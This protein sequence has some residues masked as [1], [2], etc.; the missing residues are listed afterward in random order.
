MFEYNID[1][2]IFVGFLIANLGI[3]LL[4]SGG[5]ITL[6]QYAVGDKTFSTATLAA[7]IIATCIGGGFFSGAITESYKQGLYFIIPA[8]GEPLALVLTGYLLAPRM[9]EFLK[10]LSIAEAMGELYGKHVRLITACASIFL[11]TGIVALQFKVAATILKFIFGISSFYAVLMSAIIV[12]MYSALGGVK[13]VTFM[14][15]IQF[16]TFGTIIP[17]ISLAIWGSVGDPKAVFALLEHNP[18]FDMSEVF[19]ISNPRFVNTFCLSAFFLIPMLQPVFFQRISMA[20]NVE[21]AQR[22]F[23]IGGVVVIALLLMTS[24]VGVLLRSDNPELEPNSLLAYILQSYSYP[25]LRGL[26]AIGVI[27]IIMSTAD[28]YINASAVLLSHDV[29]NPSRR[30]QIFASEITLPRISSIFIGSSAFFLAFKASSIL[31]LLVFI[32][33]FYGPIVSVPLLLAVFGFRST[34]FAVLIGMTAGFVTVIAFHVIDFGIDGVIPGFIA[35]LIF[36]ICS[37]YLFRQPGG[38]VGIKDPEPLMRMRQERKRRFQKFIKSCTHFDLMTFCRKNAPRQD[39]VYSFFGFFAII[40]VFSTMYSIPVEIQQ[41]KAELFKIVYDS[42]LISSCVFLTYPV[43]PP[44]VKHEKFIILFWTFVAPYVM[45]FAPVLLVI[46]SGFGQFQLMIILLNFVVLSVWLRWYVAITIICLYVFL[47]AEFYTFFVQEP[48]GSI[49][50]TNLQFKV[51][52][53]LLL[54]SSVLI[55]F[56]KPNQDHVDFL[57]DKIHY[58]EDALGFQKNELIVLLGM[59]SEF[60][61]NIEHESRAPVTGIA[62][63]AEVLEAGYDKLTDAQIKDGIRDIV[64]SAERLNS[65]ASNLVDL[66]RL[67]AQGSSTLSKTSVNISELIAERLALCVKLYIEQKDK[68]KRSFVLDV[69]DGITVNCDRYYVSKVLDNLIVNAIQYC[70]KGKIELS[71]STDGTMITFSI[72]DEGIGIPSESI[73][74]IFGLLTVSAKTKSHAGGRGVGLTLCKKVIELHGGEI[75]AESDGIGS[76]FRFRI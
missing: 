47:G 52:Y 4:C 36:F 54:F 3:G 31:E 73:H 71:L 15:I 17:I 11:C 55:G 57:D 24:W 45:V 38:W 76:V 35:N 29:L 42:V 2:V 28:S 6:R 32:L 27:A 8:L 75:W 9:G 34:S 25:G 72:K 61:R 26:T 74:D 39:A 65:W 40:S 70:A 46:A 58:L 43:W 67:S 41:Q 48:I 66:S 20:K 12:I 69:G 63:M 14:D 37:H 49:S 7:T 10:N 44:T 21:Q 5:V 1:T 23:M 68:K 59:K 50:D 19:S 62:S 16:F 56:L 60:L 13:A 53:G 33:G 51:M 22:A 64:T 18:M 30:Q